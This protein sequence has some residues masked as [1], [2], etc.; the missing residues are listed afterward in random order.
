[1]T[2]L[3]AID[4]GYL[5]MM[6]VRNQSD[7]GCFSFH[8]EIMADTKVKADREAQVAAER[9]YNSFSPFS[10]SILRVFDSNAT[11]KFAGS[12]LATEVT[13]L[14]KA[15]NKE[16]GLISNPY[17]L[18]G[19]VLRAAGDMSEYLTSALDAS[20]GAVA[21]TPS[22]VRSMFAKVRRWSSLLRARSMWGSMMRTGPGGRLTIDR[23]HLTVSTG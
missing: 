14:K 5:A 11:R 23:R 18:P 2:E 22:C 1:M 20:F 13:N 16:V 21:M 6:A 3:G 19:C 12:G 8:H 17:L 9:G 10:T 15:E 4:G 7:E